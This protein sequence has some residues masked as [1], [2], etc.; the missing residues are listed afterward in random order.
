MIAIPQA[1]ADADAAADKEAYQRAYRKCVR[2]Q[3]IAAGYGSFAPGK[4][5][6]RLPGSELMEP[7]RRSGW[8]SSIEFQT[9]DVV[10]YENPIGVCSINDLSQ[11]HVDRA[12]GNS[13]SRIVLPIRRRWLFSTGVE[14]TTITD[15][16]VR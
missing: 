16:M 6:L 12:K 7:A 1:N 14:V 11:V 9:S 8:S 5:P 3:K 13:S 15:A 2:Q 10:N 4:D